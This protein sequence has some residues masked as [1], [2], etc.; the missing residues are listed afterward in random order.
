MLYYDR[1][2]HESATCITFVMGC[3][4]CAYMLVIGLKYNKAIIVGS[5]VW[6]QR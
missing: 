4:L 1:V 2:D 5:F 6:H 3:K